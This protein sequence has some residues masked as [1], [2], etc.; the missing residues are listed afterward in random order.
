MALGCGVVEGL[1]GLLLVGLWAWGCG[2]VGWSVCCLAFGRGVVD[3][4]RGVVEGLASL[5][6]LGLGVLGCGRG[7]IF[8]IGPLGV[9][10]WMG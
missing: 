6:L 10:L 7:V 3:F 1:I 8:V 4:G 9:G 2:G 5:L